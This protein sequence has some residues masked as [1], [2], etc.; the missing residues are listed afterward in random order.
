[1]TLRRMLPL[2]VMALAGQG[3]CAHVPVMSP[4]SPSFWEVM[5]FLGGES[6]LRLHDSQ[7]DISIPSEPSAPTHGIVTVK[8]RDQVVTLGLMSPLMLSDAAMAEAPKGRTSE[9]IVLLRTTD[10]GAWFTRLRPIDGVQLGDAWKL[11]GVFRECNLAEAVPG[12]RVA[13]ESADYRAG[14][15][16]LISEWTVWASG[17]QGSITVRQD[18][19][20][21]LT[22]SCDGL[23]GDVEAAGQGWAASTSPVFDMLHSF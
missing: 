15:V 5:V 11:F 12:L 17:R 19:A 16:P 1:M 20:R 22:G 7:C 6:F 14:A 10:L 9:V 23:V 2:V 3:G 13:L 4:R 8:S 21:C 18:A